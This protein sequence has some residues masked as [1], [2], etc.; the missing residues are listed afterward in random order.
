VTVSVFSCDT[1]L[2]YDYTDTVY[3][4]LYRDTLYI[5]TADLV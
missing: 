1:V 2:R 5:L 4:V 3:L